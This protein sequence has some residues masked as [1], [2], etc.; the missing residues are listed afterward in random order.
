MRNRQQTLDEAAMEE[1][2]RFDD[3]TGAALNAAAERLVQRAKATGDDG[4]SS[5]AAA[6]GGG[7]LSDVPIVDIA[8]GKHKYVQIELTAPGEAPI[9]VVRSYAGLSYHADNYERAMELLHNDASLRPVRGRVIGGGRIEYSAEAKAISVYGYSKSASFARSPLLFL[10]LLICDA[11]ALGRRS[12]RSRKGLQRAFLRVDQ[13]E[14]PRL[15]R[16]LE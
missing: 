8:I 11:G 2:P 7:L 13:G 5:S 16:E 9:R 10:P 4:P 12:V 6:S 3:E 14:L 1:K 15:R